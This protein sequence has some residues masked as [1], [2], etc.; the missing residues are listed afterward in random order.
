MSVNLY[1]INND[2][3]EREILGSVTENQLAFLVENLEEEFEED[4]E[5]FISS[6]TVQYLKRAGAD[7]DLL[8][9]LEKAVAD[10]EE[11]VDIFYAVE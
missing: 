10:K 4:D 7:K 6:E 8:S 11:G 3:Y 5:Y 2:T 1:R 9:M